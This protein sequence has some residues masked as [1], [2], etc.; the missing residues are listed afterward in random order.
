MHIHMDIAYYVV[1]VSPHAQTPIE[2]NFIDKVL[3]REDETTKG[4]KYPL[5]K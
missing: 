1:K 2:N 3:K 4:A 5:S